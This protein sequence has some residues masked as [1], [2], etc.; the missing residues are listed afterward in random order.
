MSKILFLRTSD[1]ISL[2]R[3]ALGSFIVT[4]VRLKFSLRFLQSNETCNL[5]AGSVS[6]TATR[7][8]RLR[9]TLYT[10]L[11]PSLPR[12]MQQQE[13][14]CIA[15]CGDAACHRQPVTCSGTRKFPLSL[16]FVR[17]FIR[18]RAYRLKRET[19]EKHFRFSAYVSYRFLPRRLLLFQFFLS[20]FL[21]VFR[22]RFGCFSKLLTSPL[23]PFYLSRIPTVPGRFCSCTT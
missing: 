2:N 1:S 4:L 14:L 7:P 17:I 15:R 22:A 8:S 12:L 9:I 23:G 16:L 6:S 11:R 10:C 21:H 5:G 3:N 19:P 20:R 18:S 13:R